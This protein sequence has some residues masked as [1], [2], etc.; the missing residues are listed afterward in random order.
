MISCVALPDLGA[1]SLWQTRLLT[2]M[3]KRQPT[4]LVSRQQV[5]AS[6]LGV[7]LGANTWGN[8]AGL[9]CFGAVMPLDVH[10]LFEAVTD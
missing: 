2:A 6:C 9:P 1:L 7:V 8:T 5:V 3:Y 10:R 4:V